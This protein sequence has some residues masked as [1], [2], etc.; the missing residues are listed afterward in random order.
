MN[1]SELSNDFNFDNE[2][3]ISNTRKDKTEHYFSKEGFQFEDFM[4]IGDRTM[5]YGDRTNKSEKF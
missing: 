4:N 2:L 1:R 3:D 5:N